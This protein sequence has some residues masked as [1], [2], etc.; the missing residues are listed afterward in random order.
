MN[1]YTKIG[2]RTLRRPGRWPEDGYVTTTTIDHT[3]R[4]GAFPQR[5]LR[6]VGLNSGRLRLPPRSPT[7][8]PKSTQIP[9]KD[10]ANHGGNVN[11]GPAT[12][13]EIITKA[14]SGPRS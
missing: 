11:G 12:P 10:R 14:V 1:A 2:S 7:T 4:S 13:I 8:P 3:P 6:V 9:L 5:S